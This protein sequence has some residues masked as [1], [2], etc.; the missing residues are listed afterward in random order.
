[1]NNV[2][3]TAAGDTQGLVADD[4]FTIRWNKIDYLKQQGLQPWY[5]GGSSRCAG[6][7][8]MIAGSKR[9]HFWAALELR[10]ACALPLSGPS[11]LQPRRL[12]GLFIWRWILR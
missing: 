9:Q 3:C 4:W 10:S 11:A 2:C 7:M 1:M 5:S 6:L 8:L 12:W